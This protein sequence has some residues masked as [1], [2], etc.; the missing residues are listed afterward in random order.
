[1]ISAL[2]YDYPPNDGGISRL[3]AELV[4]GM[5]RRGEDVRVLTL[6][7]DETGGLVRP[8]IP[9]AEVAQRGWR[10]DLAALRFI[11]AQPANAR[12][13]ASVWNPEAT[14]VWLARRSR[15]L[16]ILAHGNE[17][18]PY[19]TGLGHAFKRW[20]RR[21]VLASAQLVI[22]NSHYTERLVLAACPQART[23]T[24]PLGVD[25]TRFDAGVDSI[26]ARASF[27]LPQDRR[28]VLSVSRLSPYKGHDTVLRAIA[29]LPLDARNQ[30]HYAIAGRGAHLDSLRAL[31]TYLGIAAQVQWLGYVAEDALPRLYASADLFVLCT[32]EDSR[33]RGVEGF[34]L[35]FL[36]A[37]AA[38]VPVLGTMA[39]GIPDAVVEGRGGW[40]VAQDDVDA[41]CAKIAALVA[42]DPA[43]VDQGRLGRLRAHGEC[44]WDVYIDKVCGAMGVHSSGAQVRGRAK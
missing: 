20:L 37:Q 40:L 18:M 21:R 33:E 14:L 43:F 26:A 23:V 25:A 34:G 7:S 1:M 9:T 27:G 6:R 8:D 41:V 32:R 42:G 39:G 36:E 16:W 19:P 12:L 15:S 13:L 35:A 31:A 22:C 44:G 38:G 30:V 17:V 2:S 5:H 29:A 24:I 3:M 28:I 4:I 10:R 11:L